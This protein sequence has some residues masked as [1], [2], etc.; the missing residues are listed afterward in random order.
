M[1]PSTD[2]TGRASKA[3]MLAFFTDYDDVNAPLDN[4]VVRVALVA[5]VAFI[6]VGTY[7]EQ[8]GTATF[9]DDDKAVGVDAQ[10]L[11]DT[12]GAMLRRGDRQH[13][14]RARAGQLP[15]D[16]P[17]WVSGAATSIVAGTRV[18]A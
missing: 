5:D 14:E 7:T 6:S 3:D 13:A 8:V 4:P 12:L 2:E 11:Y 16:H 17:A 1:T 15:A 10:L 9:K 18:R